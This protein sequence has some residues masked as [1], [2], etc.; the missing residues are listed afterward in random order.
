MTPVEDV[1]VAPEQSV[2][3]RGLVIKRN[4]YEVWK[5]GISLFGWI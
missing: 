5:W 2:A 3:I 1:G 4:L